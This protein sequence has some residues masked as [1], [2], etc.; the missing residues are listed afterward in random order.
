MGTQQS[1][2]QLLHNGKYFPAEQMKRK[3]MKEVLYMGAAV[4]ACCS[5]AT[6]KTTAQPEGLLVGEKHGNSLKIIT[7]KVCLVVEEDEK[8]SYASI[9]SLLASHGFLTIN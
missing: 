2:Y 8:K 3:L 6:G 9:W 4:K 1:A 5:G 7:K